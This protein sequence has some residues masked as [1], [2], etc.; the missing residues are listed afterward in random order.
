MNE[1]T[2]SYSSGLAHYP[3]TTIFK[4]CHMIA[5]RHVRVYVSGSEF[6]H[7]DFRPVK[8]CGKFFVYS[9]INPVNPVFP[10]LGVRC[11]SSSLPNLIVSPVSVMASTARPRLCSSFTSTRN[12]AGM[13]GSSIGSP[14]MMAS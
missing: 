9:S 14:L 7:A 11:F 6:Y 5:L 13:P 10:N 1:A 12:E 3:V 4:S 2:A 8:A